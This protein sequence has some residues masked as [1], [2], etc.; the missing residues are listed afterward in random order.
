[1]PLRQQIALFCVGGAIGLVIDAGIVQ[2]L[3]SAFHANPY[4]ARVLSF[5]AAATGT[6]LFNRSLTFADRRSTQRKGREFLRYLIA[7]SAGFVV[8]YGIYATAVWAFAL[9]RTWPAIGVAAG[10]LAG[11][12]LNFLSSRY[13]IFRAHPPVAE[14]LFAADAG[15]PAADFSAAPSRPPSGAVR[16]L[17]PAPRKHR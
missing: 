4:G 15:T 11:A 12:V 17:R 10:S 16:G 3:V 2:W 9:V 5:L 13:W 14:E 7:M 6:W 8:N 1:M